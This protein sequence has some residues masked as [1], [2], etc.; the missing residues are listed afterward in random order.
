[1]FGM[2]AK[3][4]AQSGK[5]DELEAI[6]LQA[7]EALGASADCLLYVVNRSADEPDTVWVTEAWR[8]QEAHKASLDQ[9]D[10]G[11]LVRR[12]GPLLAGSPEPIRVRPVGGKGLESS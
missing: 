11:T 4:T 9:E 10:V 8:S 1:M 6:L 12:A 5:G 2:L 7:A 3:L